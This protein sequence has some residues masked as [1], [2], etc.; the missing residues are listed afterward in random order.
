MISD[1]HNP[2]KIPLSLIEAIKPLVG[3]RRDKHSDAKLSCIFPNTK[4]LKFIKL[5]DV[6]Q[7]DE[8]RLLAISFIVRFDK[9]LKL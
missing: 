2:I 4:C 7:S 9:S 6:L 1:L 5:N 8:I 3:K